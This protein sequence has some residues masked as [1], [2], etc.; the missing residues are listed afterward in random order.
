[1][2]FQAYEPAADFPM[3][4]TLKIDE[5]ITKDMDAATAS[6]SLSGNR[7]YSAFESG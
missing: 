6:M 3:F 4:H 5:N 7:S 1:M 2:N